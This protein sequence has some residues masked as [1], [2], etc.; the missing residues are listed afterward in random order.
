VTTWTG[1]A[2]LQAGD[3]DQHIEVTELPRVFRTTLS[4]VPAKV[5]YFDI[6]QE[7]QERSRRMLGGTRRPKVGLMW[8][9]S[10]WNPARSTTLSE[11]IPI[12]SAAPCDF[13]SFQRGRQ[14]AELAELSLPFHIHDT[15]QHSPEILDT[16]ADLMNMDLLIT[17]DTMAA[18]LA[19]ALA[20][21][22]WVMLPWQADWRWMLNREDTPWYPSMRL[23]R[24][25]VEGD[26]RPAVTRIAAELPQA[27]H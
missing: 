12:L 5:P 19:G 10:D 4:T 23:F 6:S 24:Q 27:F 7:A 26:W 11:L 16:A 8:A 20:R 2:A 15:A 14:R 18:H 21:K 17:V 3:W 25:P 9:S 13:Y 22:V 1:P